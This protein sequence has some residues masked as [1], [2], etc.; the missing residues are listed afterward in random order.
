[1]P[2]TLERTPKPRPTPNRQK[3]LRLATT[4]YGSVYTELRCPQMQARLLR[5]HPRF[6]T[7]ANP[8]QYLHLLLCLL[9]PTQGPTPVTGLS[10]GGHLSVS[11]GAPQCETPLPTH[12]A[13]VRGNHA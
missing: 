5:E 2:L 4:R 11:E 10:S 7:H 8:E 3:A 9:E 13:A 12:H 6:Y 1:M